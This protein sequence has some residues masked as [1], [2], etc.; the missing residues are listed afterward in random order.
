MNPPQL[1]LLF[2]GTSWERLDR[3]E[4]F[5]AKPLHVFVCGVTAY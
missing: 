5:V 1:G 3:P 2:I 4:T